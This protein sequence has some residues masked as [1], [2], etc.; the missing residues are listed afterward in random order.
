MAI[1]PDNSLQSAATLKLAREHTDHRHVGFFSVKLLPILVGEG[2][3]LELASETPNT[4][5]LASLSANPLPAARHAGVEWRECSIWL[6]R[7]S[8]ARLSAERLV[9]KEDDAAAEFCALEGVTVQT[10]S[11]PLKIARARLL[12]GAEAGR[13]RWQQDGHSV[14]WDLF[15]KKI[16]S[17]DS[18]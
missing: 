5:W 10:D 17:V 7:D 15:S 14:T 8:A 9:L 1:Y 11:G 2:V 18:N 13:V 3:R 6:P 12:L 4:N 16:T